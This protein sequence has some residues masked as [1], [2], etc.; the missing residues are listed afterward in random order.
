MD[1]VLEAM[2][3]SRSRKREETDAR[4]EAMSCGCFL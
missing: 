3:L 2:R 4:A 1:A